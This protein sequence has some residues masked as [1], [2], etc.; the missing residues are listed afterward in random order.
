MTA[1]S[2]VPL[3]AVIFSISKGFGFYNTEY[4][5][6]ILL[7]IIAGKEVIVEHLINYIERTD[8]TTLGAVGLVLL[9]ITVISLINNIEKSLNVIWEADFARKLS[10]KLTDYLSVILICP[11]LVIIAFSFTATLKSS[12]LAQQILSLYMLSSVYWFLLKI[13]PFL[14]MVLA[15]FF[16]Y[17]LLPNTRIS[18]KS[19]LVGAFIASLLWQLLQS[20]FISYQ[21]GVSKYNAI[22][23][24]FS[25]VPLFLIWLFLSWLVILL[26]AEIGFCTENYK[27]LKE[28]DRLGN[29]NIETKEKMAFAIMLLLIKDF[30]T[31]KSF[32]NINDISRK[33]QA[34]VKSVNQV[35]TALRDLGFAARVSR[36]DSEGY[37][38]GCSPKE[39]TCWGFI[40]AFRNYK[41]NLQVFEFVDTLGVV[42]EFFERLQ[43]HKYTDTKELSLQEF[44]EQNL[45]RIQ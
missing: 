3:L 33:L 14:F 26:G 4:I 2:I 27:S 11:F 1:L 19:S 43:S 25:Q 7:E 10:R 35:I 6:K 32:L 24:S 41:D 8:L 31:P 17:K 13:S 15:I 28:S 42:E 36:G 22:Y 5:K 18:T 34:P 40:S 44:A 20:I 38:L 9:L 29:F 30:N 21:I 39:L 16:V 12:A 45:Q 37:I 23:G